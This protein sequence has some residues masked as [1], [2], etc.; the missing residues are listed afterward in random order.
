MITLV[1]LFRLSM[2]AAFATLLVRCLRL[3]AIAYAMM[4]ERRAIFAIFAYMPAAMLPTC[5]TL[6]TLRVY[7]DATMI[8]FIFTFIKNT[9]R[10]VCCASATRDAATAPCYAHDAVIADDMPPARAAVAPFDMLLDAAM[11][12][13]P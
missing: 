11:L 6:L 10:R 3:L 7:F 1:T 5:F 9:Q 2:P 8:C 4:R 13:M 12:S